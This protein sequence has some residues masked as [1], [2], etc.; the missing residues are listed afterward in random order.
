MHDRALYL[1][2]QEWAKLYKAEDGA[3]LEW[4]CQCTIQ[5]LIGLPCF[6]DLFLCLKDGGQV[7]LKDIHPFWWYD[8]AKVST[9]LENQSS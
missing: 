3:T 8:R 4:P 5:L 9:T 7:L 6:H 2:I 1:I